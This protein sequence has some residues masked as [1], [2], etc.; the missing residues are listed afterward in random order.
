[1]VEPKGGEHNEPV[2]PEEG[3][4]GPGQTLH[5][6]RERRGLT[7][8][9][10][11]TE[12]R[13]AQRQIEALEA[14]DYSALPPAPFVRGYLRGYARLLDLDGETLVDLFNADQ[15]ESIE[16]SPAGAAA[17]GGEHRPHTA[18]IA[19]AILILGIAVALGWWVWTERSDWFGDGIVDGSAEPAEESAEAAETDSEASA[20]NGSVR[21]VT[22]DTFGIPTQEPS[23][24][25][26]PKPIV[27]QPELLFPRINDDATSVA[28]R[29][30]EVE[31]AFEQIPVD[32]FETS[33]E[34]L[35]GGGD[36]AETDGEGGD[37]TQDTDGEDAPED[38]DE[39]AAESQTGDATGGTEAAPDGAEQ[40]DGS[41]ET[42]GDAATEGPNSV[43]LEIDADSWVEVYDDRE[44]RLAYG[45]YGSDDTLQLQ[46][47]EPFEIFLGNARA[48]AIE[49]DGE[50]VEL[51]G[52]VRSNDTAR[53]LIGAEGVRTP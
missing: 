12:L 52:F 16:L 15:R 3:T 26:T 32:D 35:A 40:G 5:E 31:A 29:D 39:P 36:V 51:D 8:N 6:E 7:I 45:L 23:S 1:M 42:A 48:V 22:P 14:D 28:E 13:L 10:V 2:L 34:V 53:V 33:D 44:Q 19:L 9:Q 4:R 25:N 30:A 37:S 17:T 46:G 21:I 43:T 50:A 11:A 38:A 20:D 49:L 24:G 27:L 47:W 41:D 18:R